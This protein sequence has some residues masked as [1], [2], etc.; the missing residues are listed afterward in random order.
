MAVWKTTSPSPITSAPRAVPTNARP[1]S[2][3]RAA[4]RL[5]TGNYHRLVDPVLLGDENLDPLR[6]RRGHV[7][8]DVVRPDR[9]LTMAAVDKH[10][11][12]DR[13][14]PAEVHQRVHRGP[15]RPSVV[16]HVVDQHD[17]LAVDAR[18]LAAGTA[19]V[20]RAQVKVVAV[21]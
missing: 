6:V 9:Q 3:T 18:H 15:R 21:L 11:E 4:C 7:L 17:D 14:R 8:A 2:R 16:D 5:V 12:L 1:S 20:R 13:P 10:R 19:A